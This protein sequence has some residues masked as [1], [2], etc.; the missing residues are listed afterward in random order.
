[1]KER[2][3]AED[4]RAQI[5]Q[6]ALD[7]AFEV[8]PDQ[9]TTGMIAGRLGLTQPAIYKHFNS[10]DDIWRGVADR[11]CELIAANIATSKGMSLAPEHLL[12]RLVLGHLQLVRDHPALP[13]IM[14]M[15]DPSEAQG[16][17][18]SQIRASMAG[19]KRILIDTLRA[20]QSSGRFRSDIRAQDGATLIVGV[21]Q[22]LV[23]QLLLTRDPEI[24]LGE[25]ERL[26]DLQLSLLAENGDIN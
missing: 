19:F 2:Q 13:Q 23:L 1:M 18:M 9:L 3:P 24:L 11:L 20:A 6:A 26:L 4:R 16:A 21:I 7:L 5:L 14:V 17:S 12:R 25:G 10:K 8:G 22:G 15:R